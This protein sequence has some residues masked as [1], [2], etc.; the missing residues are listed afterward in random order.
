MQRNSRHLIFWNRKCDIKLKIQE[1]KKINTG[2]TSTKYVALLASLLSGLNNAYCDHVLKQELLKNKS[3]GLLSLGSVA[4]ADI[5]SYLL[6][7]TTYYSTVY[8]LILY[9]PVNQS[10]FRPDH[11]TETAIQQVLADILL[12]VNRGD[13]AALIPMTFQQLSI[14]STMRSY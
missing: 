6:F 14:L 13:V 10:G 11:S 3:C 9:I 7:I 8:R 1:F 5:S 12:A 4:T 2:K